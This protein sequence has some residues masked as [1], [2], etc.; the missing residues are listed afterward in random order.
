MATLSLNDPQACNSFWQ[1]CVLANLQFWQTYLARYTADTQALESEWEGVIKA[2]LLG[3][4]LG[5]AWPEAYQLITGFSTF[6]ERRGYWD[7]WQTVL[8]QALVAARQAGDRNREIT[9]LTLSARLGQRQGHFKGMVASYRR[10]IHLA[11]R[12][13]DIFNEGRACT[14]LGYFY[15]EQGHWI[16]AETLCCRAL[17]LFEQIGNNHGLAHTENH[18]GLLYT[19]QRRWQEAQK[20]L[21]RA[22]AIWQ[23]TGDQYIVYGFTNL[24]VL[25]LAM[26][27]ADK[28]LEHLHKALDYAQQAKDE[29]EVGR[30]YLNIADAYRF[31][32]DMMTVETYAKQAADIFQRYDKALELS[33][34]QTILGMAYLYQSRW[35][36]ADFHLNTALET[37]RNLKNRYRELETILYIAE[38]EMV[39]GNQAQARAH[40]DEVERL[41]EE[42]G[43]SGLYHYFQPLLLKRR[44]LMEERASK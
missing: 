3:L 27:Q 24:G 39:R 11:R 28:A 44:H 23:V 10:A 29:V 30:I 20:S 35:Q 25:Y 32:G 1:R 2:I 9:L 34:A 21:E 33:Q 5:A 19:R 38:Y 4:K 16:R 18:L 14:N 12:S 26:E 6:M 42:S 37:V 22:C 17:H 36:E 43:G 7:A 13:G 40:L 8:D 15:I 41:M 31:K